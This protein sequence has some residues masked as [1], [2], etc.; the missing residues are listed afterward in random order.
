MSNNPLKQYFRRPAVYL[1]LPSKARY[2]DDSVIDV[3]ESGELPVYPM[4]AID[5]ITSKTPDAL[6]NGEAMVSLIKSCVPNIKDPWQINSIDF[7]A[8]LIAI[9]AASIGPQMDIESKCPKCEQQSL[10]SLELIRILASLSSPDYETPLYVGELQIIFKPLTYSQMNVAS[11]TQFDMQRTLN[12]IES[13]Q[14]IEERL[15]STKQALM[16]ITK[17]SMALIADTIDYIDT[18]N[19]RVDNIDHII[20]FLNNCD[21]SVYDAIREHHTKIKT[22]SDIKPLD[23]T[24]V[25]CSHEYQ[26]PI[27][28]NTSNFFE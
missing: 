3:T 12:Q 15:K 21:K 28:L 5:E 25:N 4:T 10:Y 19:T 11:L 9:R 6:F 27:T 18:P 14:N 2:Y 8:V 13:I 1:T 22:Q 20:E 26:Q 16:E 23:V 7:D 17:T 24:C